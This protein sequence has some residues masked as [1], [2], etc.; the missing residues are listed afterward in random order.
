MTSALS[1]SQGRRVFPAITLGSYLVLLGG[2]VL[3]GQREEASIIG[4][5]TDE[6]GAVMPGVTV[7]AT[8]PALQ[9]GQV[10]DVTNERGEYRLT[11]LAIGTYTV[12][13]SLSG[14]QTIRR[15]GLRLTAGFVA[16]V[17]EVMKIRFPL[18]V[19]VALPSPGAP[20][21]APKTELQG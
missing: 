21:P 10:T 7:T 13:Y 20:P 6:S 16:K 19:V 11:P 18:P 5:M 4:R 8:S 14:F 1:R 17:D 2:T 15:D 9:V 3:A 12:E